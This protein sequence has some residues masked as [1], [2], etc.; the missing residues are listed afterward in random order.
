MSVYR[1]R[2]NVTGSGPFPVDTLA[3]VNGVTTHVSASLG[4]PR[5]RQV[6][7]R[8]VHLDEY[9]WEAAGWSVSN[10]ERLA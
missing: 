4:P 1:Y 5:Q 8:A 3:D 6:G 7:I 10:I 2:Y 9:R